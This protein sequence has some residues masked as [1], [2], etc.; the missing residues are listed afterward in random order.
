MKSQYIQPH[1]QVTSIP[2]MAVMQAVSTPPADVLGIK[3]GTT[4]VQW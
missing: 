4:T 2:S 1:V 3:V